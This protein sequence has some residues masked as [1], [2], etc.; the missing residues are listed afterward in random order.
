MLHQ[1]ALPACLAT[2]RRAVR[3]ALAV[4]WRQ[5]HLAFRKEIKST[6]SGHAVDERAMM[7]GEYLLLEMAW[8]A[9]REERR[10]LR[11][12]EELVHLVRSACASDPH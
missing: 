10:R 2:T 1:S 8:P 5:R 7:V 11:E 6:G 3:C 12:R 9:R 4:P